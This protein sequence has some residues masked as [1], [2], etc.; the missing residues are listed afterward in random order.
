MRPL[1]KKISYQLT[2]LFSGQKPAGRETAEAPTSSNVQQ[3]ENDNVPFTSI[4][5]LNV[6][7]RNI[8]YSPIAEEEMRIVK[9]QP[10][11]KAEPLQGSLVTVERSSAPSYDA[12][13][14][15]WYAVFDLFSIKFPD[16]KFQ[17][18]TEKRI[19]HVARRPNL[20]N[21]TQP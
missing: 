19:K 15:E 7:A 18:F 13:S 21:H 2:A 14:Y 11:Q 6:E 12:L 20:Q 17:G 4:E 1:Q 9:I 16:L 3:D 8:I 10:G 5:E